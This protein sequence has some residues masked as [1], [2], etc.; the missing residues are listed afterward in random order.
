VGDLGVRDHFQEFEISVELAHETLNQGDDVILLDVRDHW[1]WEHAQI[2]GAIH[3]PLDELANRMNELD[4]AKEI[5]AYCHIGDR[6][7]DACL[8]LW[9]AGFRKV[10]SMTGGIEAWS[11]LIDPAV[12]KY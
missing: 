7:V 3:I 4:P 11:E 12:P 1:E 5:I 2:D 10:R 8:L 9:D 6:S